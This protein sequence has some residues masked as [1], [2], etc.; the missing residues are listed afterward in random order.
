M[1]NKIIR[2]EMAVGEHPT[3]EIIADAWTQFE[4][5]I[6]VYEKYR[7]Y[8]EGEHTIETKKDGARVTVNLIRYG[9]DNLVSYMAG[10]APKYV[11]AEDDTDA[12]AI[13]EKYDD[14]NLKEREA[15]IVRSLKIYGR[16]FELV[17][18]E[19]KPDRPPRSAFVSPERAFVVY[20]MEINPDSVF[21]VIYRTIKT[22][23]NKTVTI[24]DLYGPGFY[25]EWR[26][27][28]RTG[29]WSLTPA[30]PDEGSTTLF[31]RVPLIEYLNSED[32]MS[33]VQN[34]ISLQDALNSVVSDRQDD[35]DAFAGAMLLLYGTT[36]GFTPQEIKENKDNL[37]T[38]RVLHF[39]SKGPEGAEYLIKQMDEVGAQAYT[40]NLTAMIHKLMRVPDFSDVSFSGNASGVAMAYKLYGTHNAAKV[41]EHYFGRGFRRRCK[42]YD[43]AL[44]NAKHAVERDTS[45]DVSKM[46]IIFNYS[47]VV[48]PL[49]E[50]TA[51]QAYLGAGVSQET[52][53]NNLSIVDDVELEMQRLDEQKAADLAREKALMSD[54][55]GNPPAQQE[56][57]TGQS[58]PYDRFIP[59]GSVG[60]GNSSATI[61][62]SGNNTGGQ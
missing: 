14:Q 21:G 60:S 58:T 28:D 9:I 62:R 38:D 33:E 36:L 53:L 5:R 61:R 44:F 7:E 11:C 46:S 37:K 18:H 31:T 10:N 1:R 24:L 56:P 57:T 3:P 19:D 43:D 45:A 35:K 20:N 17:Y 6:P 40:D 29:A 50:A 47:T 16:A 25:E 51:A 22:A 26:A 54:E 49:A 4:Q 27:E 30:K 2:V 34:V 12:D 23:D 48:D 55:F 52:V 39:E 15:E 59:Q 13:I 41:T 8:Y 42:L 32:A